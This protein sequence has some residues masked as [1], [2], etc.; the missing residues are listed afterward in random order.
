MGPRHECPGRTAPFRLG[1][2][3]V[4]L[5]TRGLPTTEPPRPDAA[6]EPE[7]LR[8]TPYWGPGTLSCSCSFCSE[9]SLSQCL[10]ASRG[11]GAVYPAI[12]KPFSENI[13]TVLQ[14][15]EDRK[16]MFVLILQ[17]ILSILEII[18]KNF[19]RSSRRGAVVNE[20]D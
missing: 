16:D 13:P 19:I 8:A 12:S 20:S 4:K 5:G 3:E 10:S 14:I 6:L 15:S 11:P 17:W 1:D 2:G 18:V 7:T 9:S